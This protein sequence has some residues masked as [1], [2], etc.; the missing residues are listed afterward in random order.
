[1]DSDGKISD[2]RSGRNLSKLELSASTSRVMNLALGE[3]ELTLDASAPRIFS[4]PH[5]NKAI[6]LKH[7]LRPHERELFTAPRKVATK[8]VFPFDFNDLKLGGTALFLRQR[9]FERDRAQFFRI[10]GAAG[11]DLKILEVLDS[12]PSLDPFLVREHCAREGLNIPMERLALSPADLAAMEKFVYGEISRLISIAFPTFHATITEKFSRKILTNKPDETMRP[13]METLRMSDD[14]FWDGIFSWR[15]FLYYKWRVEMMTLYLD[16]LYSAIQNYQP[17][18]GMDKDLMQY[19]VVARPRLVKKL[20]AAITYAQSTIAIYNDA[21]DAMINREDA[22]KFKRFLL[23]GPKLFIALGEQVGLLD[24]YASLWKF[25]RRDANG[26]M[27]GL[28]Y[29]DFLVDLD[30]S[31]SATIRARRVDAAKAAKAKTDHWI[32]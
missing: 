17:R 10:T 31:L 21:F 25:R 19:I 11:D 4:S 6:I 22:A 20:G 28:E 27:T 9:E 8:V 5:L 1:M 14:E 15:G 23:D 32:V 13:L 3:R 26:P 12:L 29:A 18:G 16:E 2:R 7:T 24:H 30:E